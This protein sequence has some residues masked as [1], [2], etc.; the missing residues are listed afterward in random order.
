MEAVTSQIEEQILN[1]SRQREEQEEVL[2]QTLK[3]MVATVKSQLSEERESRLANEE[4]L[5]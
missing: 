1:E 2:V 4:R 3:E 5:L